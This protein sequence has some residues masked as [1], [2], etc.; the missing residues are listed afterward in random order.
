MCFLLGPQ[1]PAFT[2]TNRATLVGPQSMCIYKKSYE[3]GTQ[4]FIGHI[5]RVP[6][7]KIQ[8]ERPRTIQPL[9]QTYP[10]NKIHH[11]HRCLFYTSLTHS[12]KLY[13][14]KDLRNC[15]QFS[16][17]SNAF[18]FLSH[19]FVQKIHK[20]YLFPFS[21][22]FFVDKNTVCMY[23]YIYIRKA[24]KKATTRAHQ[25]LQGV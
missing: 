13:I 4:K 11:R 10:I 8:K 6:H 1:L 2:L 15:S 21:I 7:K 23:V 22:F 19:Q 9:L 17:F 16:T 3:K 18:Q 14:K 5:Q 24:T 25:S 20:Q 12:K